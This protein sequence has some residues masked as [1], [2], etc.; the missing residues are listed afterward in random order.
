MNKALMT[1]LAAVATGAT[2]LARADIDLG[3]TYKPADGESLPSMLFFKWRISF[4]W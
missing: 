2:F 1:L 3:G 4:D